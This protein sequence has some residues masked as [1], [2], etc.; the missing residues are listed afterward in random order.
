MEINIKK[1]I[2][3]LKFEAASIFT[4]NRSNR[5]WH[6]PVC[7]GI[8]A[9]GPVVLA[10]LTGSPMI[11]GAIGSMGGMVFLYMLKT[12]LYHRFVVLMACCFGM[13]VSFIA[14]A[15]AQIIPEMIPITLG[16]V[17]M[18]A[19]MVV[20]YY[21]VPMPGNFF[22]LMTATLAAY[23]PF[24][25]TRLI[26]AS[27]Y[28]SLGCMW[29]FTVACLYSLIMLKFEKP[30]PIKE[31]S[32]DG[33]DTVVIDSFIIASFVGFA[34]WFATFLGSDKPYWVPIS[35]LAIL[36]GMT[37]RSKWTRQ[38]QRIVG[39]TIGVFLALVLLMLP[40]QEYQVGILIGILACLV[41]IFVVRNYGLAAI[42]MTPMTVYMAEI[43][44]V[45]GVG[46]SAYLILTRLEDIVLGSVIG[47][48]G[49]LCIHS[50]GVKNTLRKIAF[51]FR[52]K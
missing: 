45:T 14:G 15:F 29:A 49:G 8:S 4:Y 37:L 44:D 6:M 52:A 43:S 12:P 5:P 30:E 2:K 26:E 24:D 38:I 18:F 27:G 19:T 7:A 23:M 17:A 41:E 21:Q 33:F 35:T 31:F 13:I 10:A 28:F 16:L 3:R 34:A 11:T 36:Q 25:T 20:R 47:F 50:V 40:L 22:F 32:Y 39:T 48:I 1:M 42:F 9:G 51:Y 46:S